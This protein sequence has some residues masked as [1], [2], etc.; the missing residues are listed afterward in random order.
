[1]K[2]IVEDDFALS[3]SGLGNEQRQMGIGDED[4]FLRSIRVK[5]FKDY[6]KRTS[7]KT[8]NEINSNCQQ[9]SILKTLEMLELTSKE[10]RICYS[11]ETRDNCSLTVWK[12]IVTGVIFINDFYTGDETYEQGS[13]RN[14]KKLISVTGERDLEEFDDCQR[15]FKSNLKYVAGKKLLDFGCGAGDFLKLVKPFC[16]EALGI[17]LQKN[18]ATA[19]ND[20]GITCFRELSAVSDNDYDVVVLFHVLEHLPKPLGTL[21]QLKNNIRSGGNIV[22]EVPHANDFLLSVLG[23]EAF[24]KFTL[25]SQHLILH[26]RES[27]RKMLAY[28]GFDNIQIEGVQRYSL[29]NHLTWLSKSKAGGHKS[30]LSMIDTPEL[31]NAYGNSLAKIDGTDTLVAV[32]TKP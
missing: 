4:N 22:I 12:D 9:T 6:E 29:S 19:L 20:Q 21:K 32:A 26:T 30:P 13:Y 23:C 27:L 14:E 24:K 18:Y 2:A 5:Q 10:S 28:V 8:Q 15:R 3:G 7:C 16:K 1:M 31:C 11:E 25:W 17:E